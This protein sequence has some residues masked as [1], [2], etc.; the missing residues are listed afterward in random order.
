EC[1]LRFDPQLEVLVQWLPYDLELPLLREPPPELA[2]RRAVSGIDAAPAAEPRRLGYKPLHRVVLGVGEHIVK[3]YSSD[4]K[5]A[6][7][8]RGL[9]FAEAGGLRTA[10]LEAR[11][12]GHAA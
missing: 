2:R 5:Y 9:R 8:A 3:G 1:P 7:S 4:A 6:A 12:D 10:A 11:L